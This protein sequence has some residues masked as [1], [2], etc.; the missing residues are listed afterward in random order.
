[1]A[2]DSEKA[3]AMLNRFVA[4][5]KSL[6]HPSPNAQQRR[7]H[8]SSLVTSLDEAE[9]WRRHCLRD[10]SRLISS[11]QNGALGEAALRDLNDEINKLLREKG[12]WERQVRALGGP[13]YAKEGGGGRVKDADGRFAL[14]TGRGGGGGGGGGGAGGGKGRGGGGGE[15]YYF[16]AAKELPGVRELFEK[17]AVEEKKRTR[18]ELSQAVDAAYYGLRDDEDGLLERL[19]RKAENKMRAKA[20]REWKEKHQGKGQEEETK[21][22]EK[23]GGAA[24]GAIDLTEEEE[25]QQQRRGA[26]G[27]ADELL[28]LHVELPS[29][30]E[31]E[32]QLLAKRKR[33]S[34]T[35]HHLTTP[36][37][38]DAE[39]LC[40]HPCTTSP[41]PSPLP[42]LAARVP[43]HLSQELLE[44][45]G[46][47]T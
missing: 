43:L 44:R 30:A 4:A 31:I 26:D 16:G 40:T 10:I 13:D 18:A 6:T 20:E 11:I 42:V 46:G 22:G 8:L 1:M 47:P 15:Y 37:D 17:R 7:P 19:E 21:E 9:R 28:G 33:V 38:T 34:R 25:E 45:Y 39:L 29:T 32:R 35:Q 23:Q 3:M 5:K 36:L 27:S 12:H 41:S 24:R 14:G 2:R